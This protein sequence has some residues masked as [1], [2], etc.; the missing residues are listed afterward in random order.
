[1]P[2]NMAKAMADCLKQAATWLE[3]EARLHKTGEVV[4]VRDGRDE[5]GAYAE[6][7]IHR[8]RNLEAAA[9]AF[10]RVMSGDHP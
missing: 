1:M 4:R 3:E 2:L 5:S 9:Q 6:E 10:E 8:A 7:L